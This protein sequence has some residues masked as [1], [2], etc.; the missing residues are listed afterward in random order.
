MD[1]GRFDLRGALGG[2]PA[3]PGVYRFFDGAGRALYVGKARDLKARV[4]SYSRDAAQTPRMRGML[5]EAA[6]VEVTVAASE[7][8]ALLLENNLIKSLRPKY[9]IL[10]RDDKSYPL[11]RLSAHPYPR[12]MHYRAPARA[13]SF[14]ADGDCFGPFPDGRAVHQSIDL[15]QRLF[16]LRTCPDS[17]FAN[18]SR[19]CLLHEIGRCSAPCVN[20]ITPQRYAAD[21]SAARGFLS[22]GVDAVTGGLRKRMEEAS[23]RRDYETAAALRDRLRA[24]ATVRARHFAEDRKTPDA[25]YIA[26]RAGALGACV[27]VVSVRGGRRIGE[28]RFFPQ[29]FAAGAACEESAVLC[30]F[31]CQHYRSAPPPAKIFV[32]GYA[33]ECEAAAPFLRANIVLRPDENARER[34]RQAAENAECAL[35]LRRAQTGGRRERMRALAERLQL[36]RLPER[37]ECFDVSHT[38]GEEVVAARAVFC[39]GMAQTSQYRRYKIAADKND[40]CAAI[41]E[42]VGRS[43]RRA[44]DE[45]SP[46]PDVLLIDGGAG[47]VRAAER[48]LQELL[49]PD[50]AAPIVVGIAKAPGREAGAES[51]V[52]GDGETAKWSPSDPALLL[53]MAARDEAHRFAVAGHRRRRD[54]KRGASALDSV[55]GIGRQRRKKLIARFGGLRGVADASAAELT[56]IEG[57][58]ARLAE[59]VRR[60]LTPG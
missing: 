19:P 16:G 54:K 48:R 21:A 45:E 6:R 37:V 4:S 34:L 29:T 43:L 13:A 58:G 40:D 27:N 50:V 53:L 39:G 46:L 32:C 60:A 3:A 57:V 24:L 18:R 15:I 35:A 10:F 5:A 12:V 11:L 20:K 25:D 9:N 36:P 33:D 2:V 26:A 55:P 14:A 49:P 8:E 30:A 41:G 52:T 28:S 31:L 7:D 17:V 22:G 44:L 56:T 51:I 23:E 42:A 1:G 59:R 38:A 47:Q